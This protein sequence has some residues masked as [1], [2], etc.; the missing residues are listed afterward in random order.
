MM[1]NMNKS[2][3]TGMESKLAELLLDPAQAPAKVHAHVA[4]CED[5]RRE[6]EELKATMG[7]LDAWQAPEPSPYFLTRMQARMREEREAAPTGWLARRLASL[8]A[9][10]SYGSQNHAR[11]LAAMTLTVMLLLGGGAYLDLAVWNQPQQPQSNAA[12]VHDL[13]V[14]DNNAQVLDQMEALTSTDSNNGD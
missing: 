1:N 10:F 9:G 14:L 13:Q 3:C 2:N 4:E 5:C 12:V 11:P 8:R 6:L 7:L